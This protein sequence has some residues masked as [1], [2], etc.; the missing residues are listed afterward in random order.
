VAALAVAALLFESCSPLYKLDRPPEKILLPDGFVGWTRLDYG[1]D[2]APPLPRDGQFVVVKY[3]PSGL[4][5][6]SSVPTGSYGLKKVY[7]YAGTAVVPA[8]S[9]FRATGGFTTWNERD[10]ET[11]YSWFAFY[12]TD[13]D[14]AEPE[15]ERDS[16]ADPPLGGIRVPRRISGA[17]GP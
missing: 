4:L 9:G 13:A 14:A 7:Y 8:P 15:P 10:P 5:V 16:G 12:G 6:T 1:V 2:G 17:S 3:P 11:R